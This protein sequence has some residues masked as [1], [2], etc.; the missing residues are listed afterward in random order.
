MKVFLLS[1]VHLPRLVT[2]NQIYGMEFKAI[3][4]YWLAKNEEN[5]EHDSSSRN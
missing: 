2:Y 5:I 3:Y 1:R 4:G